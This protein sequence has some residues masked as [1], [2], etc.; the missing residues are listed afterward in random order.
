MTKNL[1]KAFEAASQLPEKDQDDL[2]LAILEEL[3]ADKKWEKALADSSSSLE[4]LAKEA[5]AEYRSGQTE[6]LE[7]DSL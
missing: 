4:Y 7:P 3:K 1:M 2:A 5:L 6:P